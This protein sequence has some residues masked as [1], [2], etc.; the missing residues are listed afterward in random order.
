MKKFLRITSFSLSL[1]LLIF[2]IVKYHF[3]QVPRLSLNDISVLFSKIA[4]ITFGAGVALIFVADIPFFFKES[5]ERIELVFR[6]ATIFLFLIATGMFIFLVSI[7]PV[8]LQGFSL[9]IVFTAFSVMS[10]RIF[11]EIG[12]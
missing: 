6:W 4:Y 3:G 7:E 1:L 5:K 11:S 10:T 8:H 9:L 12:V 2:C